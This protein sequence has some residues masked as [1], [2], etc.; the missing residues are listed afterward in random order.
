MEKSMLENGMRESKMG[1]V[2]IYTQM[3]RKEKVNGKMEKEGNGK[4]VQ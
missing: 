3:D 2:C 1:K 4:Q